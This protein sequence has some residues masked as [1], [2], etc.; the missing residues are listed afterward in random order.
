ML[1]LFSIAIVWRADFRE[2]NRYLKYEVKS[3]R[4]PVIYSLVLKERRVSLV[5]HMT[6]IRPNTLPMKGAMTL[7][8]IK[9]FYKCIVM[10]LFRIIPKF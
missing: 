1:L 2:K 5:L 6:L 8:W 4:N 9:P 7:L 3:I 10:P